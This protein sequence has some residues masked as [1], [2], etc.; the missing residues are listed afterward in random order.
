M[1]VDL[2]RRKIKL[3]MLFNRVPS[4]LEGRSFNRRTRNWRTNILMG[5][6]NVSIPIPEAEYL[7]GQ[8]K[9]H[10]MLGA[11]GLLW[12]WTGSKG[13]SAISS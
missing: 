1:E 4:L 8:E 10:S 11:R 3:T 6:F 7:G 13:T 2:P 9:C 12:K 5:E